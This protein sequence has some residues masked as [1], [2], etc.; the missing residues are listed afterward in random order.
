M[1]RIFAGIAAIVLCLNFVSGV[2]AENLHPAIPP[3]EVIADLNR[4]ADSAQTENKW[5]FER[6]IQAGIWANQWGATGGIKEYGYSGGWDYFGQGGNF[7][8]G[9]NV[10]NTGFQLYQ[11]WLGMS[12]DYTLGN[13][14]KADVHADFMYGTNAQFFQSVGGFDCMMASNGQYGMAIAQ[15]CAE[16]GNEIFHVKAGKFLSPFGNDHDGFFFSDSYCPMPDTHMGVMAQWNFDDEFTL[17]AGWTKGWNEAFNSGT[18]SSLGWFGI[19]KNLGDKFKI[20]YTMCAGNMEGF[21]ST[22]SHS[23]LLEYFITE[24][25]TYAIEYQLVDMRGEAGVE[26]IWGINNCLIHEMNEKWTSG[27][28]VEYQEQTTD[29][30]ITGLFEIT[31]GFTWKPFA[32]SEERRQPHCGCCTQSRL[33]KGELLIRPEIRYDSWTGAAPLGFNGGKES[34]QFS[35]GVSLDYS[36]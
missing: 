36:F 32:E 11:L 22:Y 20:G 21:S 6:S 34:H 31:V 30:E 17:L 25:T 12:R 4:T 5:V 9:L 35:G 29:E 10:D 28:R 7:P 27:L 24:K 18:D 3:E 8:S 26:K 15:L 14:W 16:L 33:F 13:G 19:G 23:L 2:R 1:K